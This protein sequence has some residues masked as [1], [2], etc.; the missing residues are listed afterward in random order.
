MPEPTATGKERAPCVMLP[1]KDKDELPVVQ[2]PPGMFKAL[3]SDDQD[4]NGCFALV[5][6]AVGRTEQRKFSWVEMVSNWGM[7]TSS[8]LIQNLDKGML[9][10]EDYQKDFQEWFT[11][12]AIQQKF[13]R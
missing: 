13:Q 8:T 1:L 2:R 3:D 11:S 5:T 4:A 9:N 12:D 10:L 6:P 7:V